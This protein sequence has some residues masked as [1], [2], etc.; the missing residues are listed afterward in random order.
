MY[1]IKVNVFIEILLK[2]ALSK[3]GY[4]LNLVQVKVNMV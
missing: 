1:F 4:E 2:L 3:T